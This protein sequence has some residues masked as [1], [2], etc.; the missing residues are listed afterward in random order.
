MKTNVFQCIFLND[1]FLLNLFLCT[2]FIK[3]QENGEEDEDRKLCGL[4]FSLHWLYF[5]CWV[6][7]N[8]TDMKAVLL[9]AFRIHYSVWNIQY[10]GGFSY[11]GITIELMVRRLG[12]KFLLYKLC[13]PGWVMKSFWAL[14]FSFEKMRIIKI[15]LC[16]PLQSCN[17]QQII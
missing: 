13:D 16:S 17:K 14:K 1:A 10:A 6:A 3:H 15:F 11:V 2:K 12:F 8:T 5:I 4:S 9:P 7:S